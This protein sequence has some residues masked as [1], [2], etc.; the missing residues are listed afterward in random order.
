MRFTDFLRGNVAILLFIAAWSPLPA[1]AKIQV[2]ASFSIIGDIASNIGK[3]RIELRTVVGPDSDAHVYEPSPADAIALSKADVILTNGLQ[4]EGFITR[5]V[6]ASETSAQIIEVTKGANIIQDPAGGHYHFYNGKAVFHA[7]PFDPHAWQSI[8]N[9]RVYVKNIADAFCV[10]DK[11][12]CDSYRANAKIYDARLTQLHEHIQLSIKTIPENRRTVVVGHNAFRYFERDYGFH[13]LSP[14]GVSTASE[15]S[16][17]DVAGILREIKKNNAAAVFS[18]NIANSR[19]VEQIAAE[20][21][22]SLAGVL[23][24]DALSGAAGPAP[25]YIEM[26]QHNANTLIAA[27]S[28][29]Q[30]TQ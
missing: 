8:A 24:S 1:N 19:L 5:L 30:K 26:M 11:P 6:A 18:E 16:A 14:Q 29:N 15:A 4:F 17:A 2:I 10:A 23:Y 12:G 25:T 3:E 21:G 20:A 7:A 27:L 28:K 9:V 13:F 22:L